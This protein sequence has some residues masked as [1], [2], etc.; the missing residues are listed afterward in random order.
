MSSSAIRVG[1]G[2]ALVTAS[3]G[4]ASVAGPAV[5]APAAS[6]GGPNRALHQDARD[7]PRKDKQNPAPLWNLYPVNPGAGELATQSEGETE[8]PPAPQPAS[9]EPD[10][11][12]NVPANPERPATPE[13]PR[14]TETPLLV[15]GMIFAVGLFAAAAWLWRRRRTEVT[16]TAV[17][18]EA[19]ESRELV[20]VRLRDGRSVEG[21]RNP[22]AGAEVLLLDV[23]KARDASGA[24]KAADAMDSFI[25]RKEIE[26]LEVLPEARAGRIG[27]LVKEK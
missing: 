3:M 1:T 15:G 7:R 18:D 11:G 27:H 22:S 19:G 10:P 4:L 17:D 9:P 16:L 2:A 21:W 8:P 25:P 20:R 6:Q 23:V 24:E 13:S 5:A 14:T 26:E 12:G